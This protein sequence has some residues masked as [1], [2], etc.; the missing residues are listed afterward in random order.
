MLDLSQN[1][2]TGNLPSLHNKAT[3]S[4]EF[5]QQSYIFLGSNLFKGALLPTLLH[6]SLVLDLSNN[7][8]SGPLPSIQ[9][10]CLAILDLSN[11]LFSSSIQSSWNNVSNL[12]YLDFSNNNFSGEVH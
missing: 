4:F 2:I 11:N 5:A 9:S 7:S 8:L 1:Q 6:N 3:Y 10:S 12:V